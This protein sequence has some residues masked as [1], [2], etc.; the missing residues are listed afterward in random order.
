[1]F[2][3]V[4]IIVVRILCRDLVVFRISVVWGSESIQVQTMIENSVDIAMEN[5][6]CKNVGTEKGFK[7]VFVYI[8]PTSLLFY[9]KDRRKS[10]VI[11]T[12]SPLKSTGKN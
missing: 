11:S 7:V 1:M 8:T 2:P 10:S 9:F 6:S 4:L 5:L 12:S 3:K